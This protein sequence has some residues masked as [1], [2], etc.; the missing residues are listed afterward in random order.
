MPSIEESVKLAP[1]VWPG[2]PLAVQ[3]GDLG[4]IAGQGGEAAGH[5]LAESQSASAMTPVTP[6][7]AGADV[8][9]LRDV[10]Y[11]RFRSQSGRAIADAPF[12]RPS[13]GTIYFDW[14]APTD[15]ITAALDLMGVWNHREYAAYLGHAPDLD[16]GY[17]TQLR[18]VG[19]DALTAVF[20]V[21]PGS[22]PQPFTTQSLRMHDALLAFVQHYRDEWRS[23]R[24][25]SRRTHPLAPRTNAYYG[26]PIGLE[27]FQGVPGRNA[28]EYL[29]FGFMVE[30]SVHQVYRIWTRPWFAHT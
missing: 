13:G 2:P 21:D 25:P 10:D 30:N 18:L 1:A 9:S 26:E 12:E 3:P 22:V 4:L 24:Y 28:G 20:G 19:V 11:F 27:A 15:L 7:L 16:A 29:G 23:G 14:D 5:G 6:Y 8:A 17:F